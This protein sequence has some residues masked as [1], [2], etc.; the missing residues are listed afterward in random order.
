M[1]L[2][3]KVS[4]PVAKFISKL[5]SPFSHK[6]I[7]FIE[8]KAICAHMQPGDI[9]LSRTSGELGN[10]FIPGKY[11]HV[12]IVVDSEFVVEATA[13]H[14]VIKTHIFDFCRTKDY[15][16]LVRPSVMGQ[17]KQVAS[18]RALFLVGASYDFLFS[19]ADSSY[20]CSE[21]V[22]YAYRAAGVYLVSRQKV[23]GRDIL[24]PTSFLESNKCVEVYSSGSTP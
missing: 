1:R 8:Y 13:N 4:V 9:L 24:V 20:Y 2:L 10:L 12:A 18:E 16:S 3:E 21:L 14:G 7:S 22:D 23:Y 5:H 6:K 11:K 15:I 19:E 17:S